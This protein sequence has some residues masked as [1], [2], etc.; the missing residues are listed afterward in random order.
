MEA[1]AFESSLQGL[2]REDFVARWAQP[3]LLQGFIFAGGQV[4][5]GDFIL[6]KLQ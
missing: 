3:F 4:S 5:G 6:L 1:Q 2:T